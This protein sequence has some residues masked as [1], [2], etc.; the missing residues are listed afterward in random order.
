MGAPEMSATHICSYCNL[1]HE[2]IPA[3]TGCADYI[4]NQTWWYLVGQEMGASSEALRFLH[5]RE[6]LQQEI[7]RLGGN[8][9][10]TVARSAQRPSFPTV[11][12][13]RGDGKRKS[14]HEI[15]HAH[16]VERLR[17]VSGGGR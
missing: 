1:K 9:S 15:Q 16:I 11:C 8:I 14:A 17:S 5:D 6:H 7:V 2:T 4:E 13:I 12:D 3:C 10:A